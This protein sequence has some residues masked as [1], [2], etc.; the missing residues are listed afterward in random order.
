MRRGAAEARQAS[1]LSRLRSGLPAITAMNASGIDAAAIGNHEFDWSGDTLRARRA[2]ARYRFLAANI[3]DTTGTAR[4]GWAEPWTLISRGGLKIAVIGLAL[5]A[6]P[7]N[8]T[9]RNVQGLAF[10][11]G[12]AAVRRVLPQARAAADFVIEIA[13]EGAFC[14][15]PPATDPVPAPACHG[16]IVD[17]ARGLDSAS[18]DLVVSGHTRWPVNPATNASPTRRARSSG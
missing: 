5:K 16:D 14:D 8:T 2:G 9:P 3:S 15:G 1:R 13:H 18:V 10:G 6:T 7:T 11:D 12:A 4:P 17:I